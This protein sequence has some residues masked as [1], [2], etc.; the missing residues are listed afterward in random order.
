MFDSNDRI[1]TNAKGSLKFFS[2]A[3][4]HM[5]IFLREG[6]HISSEVTG[7]CVPWGLRAAAHKEFFIGP[8][9]D[10]KNK[11]N[12]QGVYTK[13]NVFNFKDCILF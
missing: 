3:A 8:P 6:S 12:H 10:V 13:L 11:N 1:S 7:A 9:R 2:K 5:H 4:V